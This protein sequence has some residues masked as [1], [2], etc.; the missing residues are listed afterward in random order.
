MI[1]PNKSHRRLRGIPV[2]LGYGDQPLKWLR[3]ERG[4][5]FFFVLNLKFLGVASIGL[6]NKGWKKD[7]WFPNRE[8]FLFARYSSAF[9]VILYS[10]YD[11]D[12]F[13]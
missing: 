4:N 5:F 11:E 9:L 1:S 10:A 12:A 7:P 6:V 2:C 3:E 13:L 8:F